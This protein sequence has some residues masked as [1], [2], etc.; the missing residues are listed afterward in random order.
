MASLRRRADAEVERREMEISKSHR[1]C[2]ALAAAAAGAADQLESIKRASESE[3]RESAAERMETAREMHRLAKYAGELERRLEKT[4]EEQERALA[5]AASQLAHA[6]A[7]KTSLARALAAVADSLAG[8]S[9][10]GDAP[11]GSIDKI[12]REALAEGGETMPRRAKDWHAF[13]YAPASDSDPSTSTSP[14][15]TRTR[16]PHSHP[17]DGDRAVSALIGGVVRMR[18]QLE[19]ALASTSS[20]DEERAR[21]GAHIE[22]LEGELG[23][24]EQA[25]E[26]VEGVAQPPPGAPL[27]ARIGYA[28]RV[29][30]QVAAETSHVATEH[31]AL[32]ARVVELDFYAKLHDKLLAQ[33]REQEDGSYVEVQGGTYVLQ[34]DGTYARVPDGYQY[35]QQEDGTY[36]LVPSEEYA[37]Y[38]QQQEEQQQ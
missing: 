36:V 11:V 24:V 4:S 30:A 25:V 5:S 7:E 37:Q 17:N 38:Y 16:H 15:S 3:R 29:L 26:G 35:A 9:G 6:R 13:S 22:R 31:A 10:A 32:E 19:D 1:K 21:V 12:N 27:S 20:V 14:T 34:E 28:G 18:R 33:A 8:G 23:R 2:E